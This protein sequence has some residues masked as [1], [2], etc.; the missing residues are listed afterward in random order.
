MPNNP[1]PVPT[2]VN[3]SPQQLIVAITNTP[4]TIDAPAFV[5]Q[6]GEFFQV[7]ELEFSVKSMKKFSNPPPS[8]GRRMKP[9][10]CF[11][12]G[13]S[14]L[15]RILRASQTWKLPIGIFVRWRYSDTSCAGFA[16]NLC[17]IWRFIH[18]VGC[19][20]HF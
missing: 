11:I 10:R 3:L 15:K 7:F 8:I 20:K 16:T 13:F 18:F 2:L 9:S 12:G 17:K 5:D 19:V 4:P 6:V 14:S 1:D